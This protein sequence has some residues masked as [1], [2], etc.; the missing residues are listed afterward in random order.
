MEQTEEVMKIVLETATKC[1]HNKIETDYLK[2]ENDKLKTILAEQ[3]QFL[4]T[5]D[6]DRRHQN[7]IITGVSESTPLTS[8]THPAMENAS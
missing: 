2:R 8:R 7:V 4:S 1:D 3:Q 6:A 5:I